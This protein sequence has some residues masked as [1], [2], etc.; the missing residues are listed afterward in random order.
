MGEILNSLCFEFCLWADKLDMPEDQI[1]EICA[2][3][4]DDECEESDVEDTA[5]V[6]KQKASSPLE[7]S[8]K[9]GR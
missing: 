3:Q 8:S 1:Q 6:P 4:D 2:A 7:G 9:T 5:S